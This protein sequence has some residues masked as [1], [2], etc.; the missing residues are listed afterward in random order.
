[1]SLAKI[2]GHE[3]LNI[4]ATYLHFIVAA[5]CV[6]DLIN[7]PISLAFVSKLNSLC[8]MTFDREMAASAPSIDSKGARR[9]STK[10]S[11][12]EPDRATV[13]GTT[14]GQSAPAA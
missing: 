9:S 1:M 13:E 4:T 7:H 3:N 14:T 5:H 10:S 2:L 8:R 11:R 12:C 6:D